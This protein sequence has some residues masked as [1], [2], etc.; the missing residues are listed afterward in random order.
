MSIERYWQAG[1]EPYSVLEVTGNIGL[2]FSVTDVRTGALSFEVEPN[3][4]R[5]FWKDI[6][7]SGTSQIQV[8]FAWSTPVIGGSS[9]PDILIIHDGATKLI[10]LELDL[11]GSNFRLSVAGSE[12]DITTNGPAITD[13]WFYFGID[14]KIDPSSGWVYVYINGVETLKFEGNTGNVDINRVR[15]GTLQDSGTTVMYWHYDDLYIN[16]T[17]GESS[18]SNPPI[19]FF[20]WLS[21]DGNGTYSQWIGSDGNSL[22]NYALVDERPPNTSDYVYSSGTNYLDSYMMGT[23]II[24]AGQQIHSIIPIVLSQRYGG[25]EEIAIGTRYSGTNA[26][27]SNQDPGFGAYTYIW[28]RQTGTPIGGAWNQDS[29]DNIELIIY[30]TGAF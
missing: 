1:A 17:D 30:S 29:L 25:G 21:P 26:V 24:E 10:E 6:N 18:P 9:D 14:C 8:G 4:T 23:H 13:T 27:G 11:A 3:L 12:Q 7:I 19:L 22:N 16:L 5:S 2:A 15:F 28:E 20:D